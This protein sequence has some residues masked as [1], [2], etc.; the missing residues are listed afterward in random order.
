MMNWNRDKC[1]KW[2]IFFALFF[3]GLFCFMKDRGY[4][5]EIEQDYY[6]FGKQF[7]YEFPD[8]AIPVEY[9]YLFQ[10]PNIKFSSGKWVNPYNHKWDNP[11]Q[12]KNP[13]QKKQ[14]QEAYDNHHFNAVRTFND[15][16]NRI[17]WLPNL[18]WRQWGRDAWIAACSMALTKT[19][20]AALAVAFST[21]LSQYGLHCM[22][23]YDDIQDKLYWSNYH[24]EQC[25]IYANLL[26]S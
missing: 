2:A 11:Q 18:T 24:F 20:S 12:K 16:Y 14:W 5:N 8:P 21:M 17:W 1:L 23:E 4:C 19:P 22:D 3:F 13:N 26:H 25:T 6:D 15:A 9:E 10:Y 7:N